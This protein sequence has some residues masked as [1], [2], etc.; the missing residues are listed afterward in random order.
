M[1]SNI[2]DNNHAERKAYAK[3][4]LACLTRKE[5]GTT[6]PFADARLL[7]WHILRISE[8]SD[9]QNAGDRIDLG[10]AAWVAAES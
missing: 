3:A 4:V 5:P 7:G 6:T 9:G 2:D 1:A 10:V 8:A